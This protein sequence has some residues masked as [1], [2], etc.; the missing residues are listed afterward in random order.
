MGV[1]AL[2]LPVPALC[3]PRH[4]ALRLTGKRLQPA[5]P[6]P[7]PGTAAQQVRAP[8]AAQTLRPFGLE[9]LIGASALAAPRRRSRRRGTRLA[10]RWSAPALAKQRSSTR[11]TFRALF[12]SPREGQVN[13]PSVLQGLCLI[14]G[15]TGP[16]W[17]DSSRIVF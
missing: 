15:V 6:D 7:Y 1:R 4:G 17:N 13:A 5:H 11:L 12:A 16:R 2:A 8:G 14:A 3:G 9:F 10:M